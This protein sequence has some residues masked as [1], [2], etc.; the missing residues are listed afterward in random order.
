MLLQR[1]IRNTN[2]RLNPS[3]CRTRLPC[4]Y[5]HKYTNKYL[6]ER[7]E[8]LKNSQ[9]KLLDSHKELIDKFNILVTQKEKQEQEEETKTTKEEEKS[10][11]VNTENLKKKTVQNSEYSK[12]KNDVDFYNL[13]NYH[14][15]KNNQQAIR[16]AFVDDF[17]KKLYKYEDFS[18]YFKSKN[19][20]NNRKIRMSTVFISDTYGDLEPIFK[21]NKKV[22]DLYIDVFKNEIC[23]PEFVKETI[24]NGSNFDKKYTLNCAIIIYITNCTHKLFNDEVTFIEMYKH[25]ESLS[26][27][28]PAVYLL[29]NDIKLYDREEKDVHVEHFKNPVNITNFVNNHP[30]NSFLNL[31]LTCTY[32]SYH[33]DKITVDRV[34]SIIEKL[35]GDNP[36]VFKY[37]EPTTLQNPLFYATRF[38]SQKLIDYL[39]EKGCNPD[40]V[41]CEACN[42]KDYM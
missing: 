29:G 37:K 9:Q 22:L 26:D 3:L 20:K 25:L 35:W 38:K 27:E 30:N 24:S 19:F 6:G 41:N 5:A 13:I 10:V 39:I 40:D 4:L 33:N 7:V 28:K 1:L 23:S 15:Q 16:R 31:F 17:E 32:N 18:T 12:K 34:I 42:Y 2:N 21:S 36:N 8:E 11:N 14:A